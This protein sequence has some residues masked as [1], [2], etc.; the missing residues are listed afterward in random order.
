MA[1]PIIA[2]LVPSDL[3]DF[4]GKGNILRELDPAAHYGALS[5]S[6]GGTNGAPLPASY[7]SACWY[8]FWNPQWNPK[9]GFHRGSPSKTFIKSLK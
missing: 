1:G 4:L 7:R 2:E 6:A 8:A 9:P 3:E 5:L